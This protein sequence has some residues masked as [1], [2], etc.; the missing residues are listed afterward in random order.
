MIYK[1]IEFGV[2][3]GIK[4][5]VWKWSVS[6]NDREKIGQAKTKSDAVMAAWRAIDKAL[7]PKKNGFQN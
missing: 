1:D 3:Q 7:E 2:V 5:G 6:I 4:P